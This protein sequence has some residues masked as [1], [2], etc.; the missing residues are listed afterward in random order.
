M[1][2]TENFETEFITLSSD[3]AQLK[4]MIEKV[5]KAFNQPVDEVIVKTKMEV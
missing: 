2:M 5:I 1:S 4:S 3:D